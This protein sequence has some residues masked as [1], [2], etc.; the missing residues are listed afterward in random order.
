MSSLI[1]NATE[2][3]N[4]SGIIPPM[5]EHFNVNIEIMTDDMKNYLD[6]NS[7]NL[8]VPAGDIPVCFGTGLGGGIVITSAILAPTMALVIA[9]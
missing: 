3:L 1:T 9:F 5:F 2:F 8:G 4:Y 7:E 6:D